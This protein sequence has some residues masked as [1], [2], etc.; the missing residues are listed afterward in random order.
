MKKQFEEFLI[1]RG[2]KPSTVCDY[3][4]RVERVCK[5]EGVTWCQLEENIDNI[6]HL[7]DVGGEK[8]SSGKQSH[9]SVINALRRFREFVR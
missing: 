7:Y 1:N 3:A 4:K 6:V 2:H 8:E 5:W 9:S